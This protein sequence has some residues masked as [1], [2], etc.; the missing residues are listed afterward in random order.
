MI[1]GIW[2]YGTVNSLTMTRNVSMPYEICLPGN[3]KERIGGEQENQ[4]DSFPKQFGAQKENENQ[5]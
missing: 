4:E 2:N 5:C 1:Q 3:I